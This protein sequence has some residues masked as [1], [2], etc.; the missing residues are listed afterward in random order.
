MPPKKLGTEEHKQS[1]VAPKTVP[2]ERD[3]PIVQGGPT[4]ADV[5]PEEVANWIAAGWRKTS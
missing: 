3:E 5:H 4:R 1:E 2:M